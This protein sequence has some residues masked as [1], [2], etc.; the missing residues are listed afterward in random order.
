MKWIVALVLFAAAS[1]SHANAIEVSPIH[2]QLSPGHPIETLQVANKSQEPV[3][4]QLEARYWQQ[5]GGKDIYTPTDKLIVLP[6]IVTISPG[7]KQFVRVASRDNSLHVN[8]EAYRVY[9]QEIPQF[10][11]GSNTIGFNLRL[12]IPVFVRP[13]GEFRGDLQWSAQ[14]NGGVLKIG[15]VNRMRY[16]FQLHALSVQDGTDRLLASRDTFMYL[17]S[18]QSVS[19][20]FP[21]ATPL[22]DDFVQL[23]A[24]SDRGVIRL[25]IPLGGQGETNVKIEESEKSKKT[26]KPENLHRARGSW[27]EL[28]NPFL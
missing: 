10:K 8:E 3:T 1:A 13:D 20:A 25:H 7:E 11:I 18:G 4:L 14:V 17:L 26:E 24:K 16:H 9:L 21:L 15:I 23:V 5:N 12:G 22:K 2:L 27:P 19:L 28:K 6:V